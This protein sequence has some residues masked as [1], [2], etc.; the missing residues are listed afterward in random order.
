MS[1]KLFGINISSKYS[2]TAD[3]VT[4]LED[5]HHELSQLDQDSENAPQELNITARY[6]LIPKIT[7]SSSKEIRVLGACCLADMLRI[8]APEAPF[9]DSDTLRV[10]DFLA[11]QIKGLQ[12][13][14]INSDLGKRIVYIMN[15]LSSA[16]KR[17]KFDE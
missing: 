1:N 15:S 14:D 7:Q 4:Y 16:K 6:L 12:T 11:N 17:L 3:L 5:L 13:V 9:S 10:I 8:F 2:K